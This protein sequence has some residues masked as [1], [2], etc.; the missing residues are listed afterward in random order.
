MPK[1]DLGSRII[2]DELPQTSYSQ[3]SFDMPKRKDV[4]QIDIPQA[5]IKTTEEHEDPRF[6]KKR[7]VSRVHGTLY[8]GTGSTDPLVVHGLGFRQV[9][10]V[11]NK[12]K[13]HD[14][15]NSFEISKNARKEGVTNALEAERR[16]DRVMEDITNNIGGTPEMILPVTVT[17]TKEKPDFITNVENNALK[18]R[19]EK[20]RKTSIGVRAAHTPRRMG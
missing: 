16:A 3:S 9:E 6:E 19:V 12:K 1:P 2:A 11:K 10:N 15:S 17:N 14:S 5:T 4:I 18:N 13:V 8:H 7:A 20:L